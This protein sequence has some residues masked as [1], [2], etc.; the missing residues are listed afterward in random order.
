MDD[1]FRQRQSTKTVILSKAKDLMLPRLITQN[2]CHPERSHSVRE[3][4][5]IAE[6]K[7][8][9]QRTRRRA[10]A[11]SSHDDVSDEETL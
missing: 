5:E 10:A 1:R 3:A 8:P 11:E 4:N 2:N 6:S 7:D 9:L